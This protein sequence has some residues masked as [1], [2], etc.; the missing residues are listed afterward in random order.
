MFERRVHALV[1]GICLF[2]LGVV[3]CTV[4]G[5][6]P[7]DPAVQPV[8]DRWLDWM[9]DLRTDW[10]IDLA[11]FMSFLGS[12]TVTLPL[13]IVVVATLAWRR[14]WLQLTAFV[15]AVVTSE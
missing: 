10:L 1:T 7:D 9:V 3:L 12:A 15:G 14:R 6:E 8:D 2:L 11:K 4:V 5:V 13:R